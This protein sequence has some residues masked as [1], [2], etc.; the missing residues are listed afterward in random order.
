MYV[1]VN[2][3]LGNEKLRTA[4]MARVELLEVLSETLVCLCV[5][6]S[7]ASAYYLPE[8]TPRLAQDPSDPDVPQPS[9]VICQNPSSS[10]E[11]TGYSGTLSLEAKTQKAVRRVKESGCGSKIYQVTGCAREGKDD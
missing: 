8:C 7:K 1:L 6:I 11:H 9:R 3:S 2:L 10:T 4:L 5:L